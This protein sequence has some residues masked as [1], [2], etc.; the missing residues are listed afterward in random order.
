MLKIDGDVAIWVSLAI[1]EDV[2]ETFPDRG[3]RPTAR[4]GRGPVHLRAA[5]HAGFNALRDAMPMNC[6]LRLD[7]VPVQDIAG[8]AGTSRRIVRPPG[9]DCRARFGDA[10]GPY[11]FGALL[12]GRRVLTRRWCGASSGY[13]VAS[14]PD[15]AAALRRDD[16]RAARDAGVGEAPGSPSTTSSR[17]TSPIAS[18]R[19]ASNLSRTRAWPV[20]ATRKSSAVSRRCR[21][22]VGPEMF[23]GVAAKVKATSSRGCGDLL[24][25][26]SPIGRRARAPAPPVHPMGDGARAVRR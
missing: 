22:P 24:S 9:A 3:G 14:L 18:R 12:G 7:W 8:A 16:G 11:L 5:M 20:K 2:A 1:A 15:V 17:W 25:C 21:R 19:P 26:P 6:E 4:R 23:G 13:A 10:A